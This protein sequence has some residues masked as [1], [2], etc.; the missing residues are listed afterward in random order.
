MRNL[1][2]PDLS[3]LDM[4][5]EALAVE[6]GLSKNTIL[7][8]RQDLIQAASVIH[9]VTS[10]IHDIVAYIRH[11]QEEHQV[12]P[13]TVARK[14]SAL[15]HLYRFLHQEGTVKH[16]PMTRLALP[17]YRVASPTVLNVEEVMQLLDTAKEDCTPKGNRLYALLEILYST[18]LRISEALSI[19][20]IA[21]NASL[22]ER[23]AYQGVLTL[24]GKGDKER[25]VFLTDSAQRAAKDFFQV[26]SDLK[27][28]ESPYLFSGKSGSWPRQMAARALKDVAIK[29]GINPERIS[30]HGMR[31]SFATHLLEEGADL[32][33]IKTFLGHQDIST[34][35]MYTHV[36]QSRLSALLQRHHP[37]HPPTLH[38]TDQESSHE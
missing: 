2:T 34:T 36:T 14:L 20:V 15:R 8:Y 6:K 5:L 31:H 25:I 35:Q 1:A 24:K 12:H 11:L 3:W 27:Y 4:F 10:D 38:P 7:A 29:A 13:R 22:K 37:L 32:F 21:M 18:G 16:N 30:P 28:A 23:G 9:V 33:T 17:K 19:S 26:R